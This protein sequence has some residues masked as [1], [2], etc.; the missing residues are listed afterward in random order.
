MMQIQLTKSHYIDV[1]EFNY[2]LKEKYAGKT[3]DG[4]EKEAEKV[5][6][7]YGKLESAIEGF[8]KHNQIASIGDL[9]VDLREYV[10]M[11]EE[12]N[13]KAV[14]DIMSLLGKSDSGVLQPHIVGNTANLKA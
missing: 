8:I 1:D 7:Y 2:T 4:K 9:S 6:G 11:V 5:I 3:K 13:K 10:K 12:V 14:N